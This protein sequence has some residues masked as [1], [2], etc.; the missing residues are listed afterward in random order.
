MN[1]QSLTVC[2]LNQPAYLLGYVAKEDRVF[3]IDKQYNVR[4]CCVHNLICSTFPHV[5]S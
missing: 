1:G 3:L 5:V 2:H 4:T